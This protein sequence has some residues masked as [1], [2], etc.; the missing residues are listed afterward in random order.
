MELNTNGGTLTSTE[1]CDVAEFGTAWFNKNAVTN[2]LS[3]AEVS[4]THRKYNN[5]NGVD[6][7][8]V[9][10]KNGKLLEFKRGDNNLYFYKPS[11]ERKTGNVFVT[12]LEENKK[13]HTKRQFERAKRAR[14]FYHAMGTPSMP[15]LLAILRMNVVQDNPITIED[16]KL[17]EKV[18][19][20]DV[21]TLKGK[22]TRRKL[23]PVVEDMIPVPRELIQAQQHVTLTMDGLTIN[24]LKFLATISKNLY[25]R[26]AHFVPKQM[27][28]F[29]TH[30]VNSLVV[31]YN[32]GGFQIKKILCDNEFHPMM[33]ALAL[34]QHIAMNYT[35]PQEHV[36]EAERNIRVI[37]ERVR[38]TYHRLPYTR[39]P[40][41][42]VKY[43]VSEATKK[44][45]FF[46]AKNRISQYYYSSRMIL[47]QQ[48][49]DFNKHCKYS[50][51]SYVQGHDEPAPSNTNAARTL[52]CLY[53]RYHS[54]A[55]GGH[56]LLHLATNKVVIRRKITP[57]PITPAIIKRVHYLAEQ[58][59]MPEGL[60]IQNKQGDL[61]YDS[62]WIEG[63]DYHE[64]EF[65]D[66]DYDEENENES[67][68]EE[69]DELD[70]EQYDEIDPK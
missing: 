60:K 4:D 43:L 17:A 59:N 39:L 48:N 11:A 47:H 68:T 49:Q 14:D 70:K 22:T 51:G 61:L 1:E 33:D 18:F 21:A 42:L 56:E 2:I 65:D 69:E 24:S 66:E 54:V 44:L 23:I 50:I 52:D 64:K 16:V 19:G 62:A 26:T 5:K 46:R 3:F 63:L 12:T 38:A 45:N 58:D 7:F 6:V 25:Y 34:N 27:S 20:P 40:K 31:V 10:M 35:N 9:H 30:V 32:Q 29:Y 41:I 28:E 37:K 57:V 55:Q 53:L 13:F 8:T 67:G 15:D 36:P